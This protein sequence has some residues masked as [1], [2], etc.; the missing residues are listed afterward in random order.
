MA[1]G[2]EK[3]PRGMNRAG[4]MCC[5][6]ESM[7]IFGIKVVESEAVPPGSVSLV[8]APVDV[9]GFAYPPTGFIVFSNGECK[10]LDLSNPDGIARVIP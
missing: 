2:H 9:S 8:S 10:E 7:E 4:L 1:F 3:G 6:I 5:K